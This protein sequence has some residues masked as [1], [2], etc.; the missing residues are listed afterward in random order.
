[1][2]RRE[3]SS[4]AASASAVTGPRAR[5]S[6]WMIWNSRS[7]LRIVAL[8]RLLT[9]W[10]QQGRNRQVPMMRESG[11]L[12]ALHTLGGLALGIAIPFAALGGLAGDPLAQLARAAATQAASRAY[13][14]AK[15]E[16]AVSFGQ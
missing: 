14:E 13:G 3:V 6:A 2:V 9:S 10:W 7:A 16:I 12:T 11:H 5:R 1:M 4:S 15:A 8:H